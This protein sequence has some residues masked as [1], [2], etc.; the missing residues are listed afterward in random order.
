LSAWK[1]LKRYINSY[2]IGDTI[3]RKDI[4]DTL[5]YWSMSTLDVYCAHLKKLGILKPITPGLYQK[6]ID[7]PQDLSSSLLQE[8]AYDTSWKLWFIPLDERIKNASRQNNT[9]ASKR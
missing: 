3:L 1:N 8:M 4:M 9:E 5:G 7:I 6:T 2:K